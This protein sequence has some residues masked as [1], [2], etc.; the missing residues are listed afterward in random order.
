MKQLL[1][2]IMC[3]LCLPSYLSAKYTCKLPPGA[4]L[5]DLSKV[6]DCLPVYKSSYPYMNGYTFRC[7]SDFIL[8]AKANTLDPAKVN[9]GDV[10]WVTSDYVDEFFK[11]YRPR[12]HHPFILITHNFVGKCDVPV[13][14]D[15]AHYLDDQNL[16]GWFVH[17]IDRQHP[18]LHPLPLGVAA[19]Y[20]AHGSTKLFDYAIKKFSRSPKTKLLYMNFAI[21]TCP[22]ERSRAYNTF[23][24]KDFC[25]KAKR[26]TH[27]E[28][29]Q[30]L[31]QH[32]FVLS[33]RGNAIDCYRTWE[34]LLMGSFPVVIRSTLDPLY[35]DLPVLILDSWEEA[36]EEFLEQKY[37]ELCAKMPTYK[38]ERLYIPYWL[39]QI[40]QC[41]L[42]VIDKS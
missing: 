35:E 26:T 6:P 8:D 34:T 10:I 27:A 14:G 15:Q 12:I 28:Y 38:F 24:D 7:F 37:E 16:L 23:V 1:L 3:F 2:L 13:P 11:K 18:K 40:R 20:H 39:D 31:A 17:N 22:D 19:S 25:T 4:K 21:G 41:Q 32:K 29:L 30:E 9:P 5:I 33:P 42:S 36:T